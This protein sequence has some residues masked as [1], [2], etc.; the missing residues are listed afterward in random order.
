MKAK[1]NERDS[2]DIAVLDTHTLPDWM[3]NKKYVKEQFLNQNGDMVTEEDFNEWIQDD[4]ELGHLLQRNLGR[5]VDL[6]AGA[7]RQLDIRVQ[8]LI[9]RIDKM[10]GNHERRS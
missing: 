2:D 10:E 7:V 9:T 5:T 6:T 1:G 4:E 3:T 8:Q